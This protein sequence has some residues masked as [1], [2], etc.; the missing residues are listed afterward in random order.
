MF[1]MRKDGA[2]S[3]VKGGSFFDSMFHVMPYFFLF[4]FFCDVWGEVGFGIIES[5]NTGE[6]S[7]SKHGS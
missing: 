1:L 3:G 5:K 7:V 4:H 2:A 6:N